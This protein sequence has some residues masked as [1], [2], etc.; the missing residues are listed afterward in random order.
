M[1]KILPLLFLI[2]CGGSITT[3]PVPSPMEKGCIDGPG[4]EVSITAV[5]WTK[6]I[7]SCFDGIDYVTNTPQHFLCAGTVLEAKSTVKFSFDIL[8]PGASGYKYRFISQNTDPDA[9]IP[10]YSVGTNLSTL[11]PDRVLVSDV[12]PNTNF[13]LDI[14]PVSNGLPIQYGTRCWQLP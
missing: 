2:A 10:A 7:G 13:S 4:T 14:L 1:K 5:G 3:P 11:G 8:T 9:T 12:A 6:E